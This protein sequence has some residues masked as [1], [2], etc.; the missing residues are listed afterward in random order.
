MQFAFQSVIKQFVVVQVVFL[1]LPKSNV[2]RFNVYRTSNVNR[3][4]FVNKCVVW[5][6]VDLIMPVLIFRAKCAFV[7]FVSPAVRL[8][9]FV[10]AMLFVHL[11]TVNHIVA[12]QWDGLVMP[13]PSVFIWMLH[14]RCHHQI[15]R[16]MFLL[17]QFSILDVDQTPTVTLDSNAFMKSLKLI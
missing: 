9:M 11:S 1:V 7:R 8:K 3:V 15:V 5:P 12:V 10:V 13:T 16:K 2:V 17:L 6:V 4:R 14:I